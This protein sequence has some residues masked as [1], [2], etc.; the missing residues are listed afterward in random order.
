MLGFS[1]IMPMFEGLNELIKFS[2]SQKCFVCDFVA[3]V[4]IC[5]TYVY[6]WSNDPQNAY[7]SNVFHG[8]QNLFNETF[9][10]VVHEWAFDLNTKLENLNFWITG[11]F[12]VMM[13]F[14]CP[15]TTLF[16]PMIHALFQHT[17]NNVQM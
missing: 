17:M 12:F 8:Y 2:Q 7:L 13:H 16:V 5:Q 3:A 6:C 4:K 9:N 1:C 15:K 10:V 14:H 11:K